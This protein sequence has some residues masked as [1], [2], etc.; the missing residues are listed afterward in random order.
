MS[1]YRNDKQ[2]AELQPVPCLAEARRL[3][4]VA[5]LKT[6]ATFDL[7]P[8]D[9]ILGEITARHSSTGITAEAAAAL[10]AY[11]I[12]EDALQQDADQKRARLVLLKARSDRRDALTKAK[13]IRVRAKAAAAQLA[14]ETLK[15]QARRQRWWAEYSRTGRMPFWHASL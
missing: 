13:R 2:R 8:V 9:E 1:L 15:R 6:L 14:A 11:P 5:D 3:A 4:K 10:E 7:R 12:S